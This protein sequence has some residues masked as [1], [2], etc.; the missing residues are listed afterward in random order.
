ML[1]V[2]IVSARIWQDDLISYSAALVA[3]LALA[4][5]IWQGYLTRLQNRLTVRPLLFAYSDFADG[6]K[7]SGL[8]LT[9][10]GLAPQ[11]SVRAS[12]P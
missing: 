8:V 5:S 3:L 6:S 12:F 10:R 9:N 2:K 1:L 7:D 11:F 4:V